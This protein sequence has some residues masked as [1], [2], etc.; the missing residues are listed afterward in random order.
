[1]RWPWLGLAVFLFLGQGAWGGAF[2]DGLGSRA[3]ARGRV[4]VAWA[5]EAAAGSC[6]PAG[7]ASL[8]GI[9]LLVGLAPRIGRAAELKLL[10]G[11]TRW[12]P[13][14]LSGAWALS[15]KEAD[16]MEEL[17]TGALALRAGERLSLGIGVKRYQQ[18]SEGTEATEVALDL[19]VLYRMGTLSLGVNFGNV[20]HGG[21][22]LVAPLTRVGGQLALGLLRSGGELALSPTAPPQGSLGMELVLFAPL[23]LR[24][25]WST[26]HWS[27]GLGFDSRTLRVDFAL[28]ASEEGPVWMLSTEAV[29]C[30]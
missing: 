22:P 4:C 5:D 2:E 13:L 29:F 6:N 8:E 27:G 3:L 9:H 15:S 7:P 17:W 30:G 28:R 18:S 11:A 16:G 20:V 21:E 24:L 26:G 1:M 25:G 10:S 14:A 23:I 19:G 12:G